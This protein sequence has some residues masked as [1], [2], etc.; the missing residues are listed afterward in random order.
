MR[1]TD[2][3]AEFLYR[4]AASRSRLK[5]VATPVGMI[6]W[7]GLG[8]LVVFASLGLDRLLPGQVVLPSPV[9]LGL[10]VPILAVG[11]ILALWTVVHFFKVRGS[12]VPVNPPPEMVATGL[13][14]RVRNPM[15]LGWFIIL[16]GLGVLLNSVSLVFIFT[17]LFILAN[18]YYLKVVEEKELEKKFGERYLKYKESVPMFIPRLTGQK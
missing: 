13:Y 2:R 17:P 6:S 11:S 5:V 12:P 18:V 8:G 16:F 10:A 4:M 1:L 15:L 9:T 14:R 7:L 3:Y